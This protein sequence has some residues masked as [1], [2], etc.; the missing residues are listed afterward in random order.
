MTFLTFDILS[1]S[2]TVDNF[3][4]QNDKSVENMLSGHISPQNQR[5]KVFY[6]KKIYIIFRTTVC[7]VTCK[8]WQTNIFLK[9]I[10]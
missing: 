9:N 7:I 10:I 1:F 2:S 5:K 3:K 6:L 8:T 4:R